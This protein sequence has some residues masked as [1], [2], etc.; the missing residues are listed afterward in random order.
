MPDIG[1]GRRFSAGR[2]RCGGYFNGA[3]IDAKTVCHP[4]SCQ[5]TG[6]QYCDSIATIMLIAGCIL[7]GVIVDRIGAGRALF[8]AVCFRGQVAGRFL[9]SSLLLRNT[10]LL[11]MVWRG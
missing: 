1:R 10:F 6:Q 11:L 4:F 9:M 7:Y 3:D 8:L 5:F 2:L